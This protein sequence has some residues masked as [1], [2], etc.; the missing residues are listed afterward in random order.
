M[1][2]WIT[3][4]KGPFNRLVQTFVLNRRAALFVTRHGEIFLKPSK[5]VQRVKRLWF[6]WS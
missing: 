3:S 1:R 6:A 5:P 2:W 4:G